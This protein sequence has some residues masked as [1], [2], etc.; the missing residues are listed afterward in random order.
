LQH[1]CWL[2]NYQPVEVR[3]ETTYGL[4]N[5]NR[6]GFHYFPD[7][8]HYREIDLADWLPELTALGASWLTLIAPSERAIPESFIRGLL[9]AH[10]EPVLHFPMPLHRPS[11]I[12]D[13]RL[14]YESYARWGARYVVLFDR[15]NLRSSWTAQSW[16]QSDLVE[17]FLDLFL[18]LAETA[19]QTGLIPVFP[20]LEPGGDYWDTAFLRAAL[21]GIQR[22][23][24]SRLLDILHIGA[25]AWA[26]N[27]PLNWGA[28]GPERWPK[29]KP[30]I[31]V[32]G[33]EDQR[34]FRIFDWYQAITEA[35]LGK[36]RPMLLLRAGSRPGDQ[37]DP[38]QP[39]ID[40]HAHAR[41]NLAIIHRLA[42]QNGGDDK[43]YEAVLPE[44][45]DFEPIPPD[46]LACNFW[47]L[48]ADAQNPSSAQAWF[49]P[50]GEPLPVVHALRQ[51]EPKGKSEAKT[52]GTVD[53]W[54]EPTQPVRPPRPSED[55]C[56][57]HYL[58]LPVYDWGIDDWH[59][60]SLR[61]F[62]K[63]NHP[64]IGFLPKEA[65]QAERVT[66]AGGVQAFPD[67]VLA[68]LREA[69]CSVERILADGTVVATA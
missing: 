58:L 69:G 49:Q 37:D 57:S 62:I 22:R 50:D 34:G 36:S 1:T 67:E 16:A 2:V 46:V 19:R 18:P 60:D 51:W 3:M 21:K 13:L 6:L 68:A 4:S 7:T 14:L 63:Q 31:T 23:N 47:L 25:Y 27:L 35:E 9:D 10:I 33:A 44:E 59:L 56:I 43:P 65:R 30:Y 55:F 42:S 40:I 26:S 41:R 11:S 45:E 29:A 61:P 53:V 20:P 15:P 54:E 8:L 52:A 48:A 64:T 28:G 17:R 5:R 38:S 66:V 24:G 39:A 12:A 32:S